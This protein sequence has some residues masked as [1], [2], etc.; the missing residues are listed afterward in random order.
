MGS[1]PTEE[2]R[3]KDKRLAVVFIWGA[4]PNLTSGIL[5]HGMIVSIA[6]SHCKKQYPL[7]AKEKK[8]RRRVSRGGGRA[9]KQL[10]QEAASKEADMRHPDRKVEV[11]YVQASDPSMTSKA[12]S[13]CTRCQRSC[14]P[15][16]Q[17]R[18]NGRCRGFTVEIREDNFR[19]CGF[20]A[21]LNF[22]QWF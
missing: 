9:K 22:L 12:G 8:G 16:L 5:M 6:V 21:C 18:S 7:G 19:L 11:K 20:A 17:S 3:N 14:L 4:A 2:S 13:S 1:Q 10:G 15:C